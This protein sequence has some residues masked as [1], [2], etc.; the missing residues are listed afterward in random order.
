MNTVI[1]LKD[2]Q[3]YCDV[4]V[5]VWS[6]QSFFI[7]E[8]QDKNGQDMIA[9]EDDWGDAQY[10]ET[11][12][13]PVEITQYG[14]DDILTICKARFRAYTYNKVKFG[15]VPCKQNTHTSNYLKNS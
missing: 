6:G 3:H 15:A 1:P 2:I 9:L 7:T 10:S 5:C 8:Y 12:D 4:L 14:E 13:Y 11:P